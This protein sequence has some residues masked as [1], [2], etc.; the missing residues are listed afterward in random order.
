M[1]IIKILF[2][3]LSASFIACDS[4]DFQEFTSSSSSR[5]KEPVLN[6]IKY[7][8]TYNSQGQYDRYGTLE[9]A[10]GSY[11]KGGFNEGL[12]NGK[13][14]ITKPGE[15]SYPEPWA[16]KGVAYRDVIYKYVG[17]FKEGKA[18]GNGVYS[19]HQKRFGLFESDYHLIH[20]GEFKEGTYYDKKRNKTFTL[21]F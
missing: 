15:M 20:K 5:A 8:G 7:T 9:L 18:H 12:Y 19:W 1:R 10:N 13:G 16:S 11:Y 4:D 6:T 3:T 21:A 14:T 2:F 17:D